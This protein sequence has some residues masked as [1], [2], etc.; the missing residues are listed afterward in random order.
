M[1]LVVFSELVAGGM[2]VDL[3]A[4][5]LRDN[6]ACINRGPLRYV[7]GEAPGEVRATAAGLSALLPTSD[8]ASDV[9]IGVAARE[10]LAAPVVVFDTLTAIARDIA[11]QALVLDWPEGNFGRLFVANITQAFRTVQRRAAEL[12]IDLFEAEEQDR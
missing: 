3:A 12:N 7:T 5:V 11:E 1:L 2:P 10:D 8:L 4:K 9:W 6:E